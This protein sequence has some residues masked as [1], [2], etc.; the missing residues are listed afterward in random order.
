MVARFVIW[1][2]IGLCP[3][4]ERFAFPA[5][6]GLATLQ[7]TTEC[8]TFATPAR[9]AAGQ[10]FTKPI[11]QGLEFRLSW[12]RRRSWH[13]AVG[14]VAS[15]EDYLSVVSPP[16]RTAPHLVI[17]EGYNVTALQS[18]RLSPR[19]FRFVTSARE[20]QEARQLVDRAERDAGGGI[21]VADIERKGKGSLE[22]EITGFDANGSPKALA[23]ISVKGRACQPR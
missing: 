5:P 7:S 14:P 21:T 10:S 17:G 19:Q 6:S 18:A 16:L 1:M 2:V 4:G 20:Y 8:V 22:L 3:L 15:D 23:W 12:D 13:I 9:F 11:G